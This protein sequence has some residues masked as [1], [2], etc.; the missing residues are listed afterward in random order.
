M[1]QCDT[2]LARAT[3]RQHRPIGLAVGA[4]AVVARTVAVS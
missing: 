1:Q 4:V 2:H 3:A